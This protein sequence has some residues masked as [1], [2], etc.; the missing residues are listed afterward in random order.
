MYLYSFLVKSGYSGHQF[1]LDSHMHS[2]IGAGQFWKKALYD[3]IDECSAMIVLWSEH[4]N[5]SKWCFAELTHA[6]KEGKPIFP[7]VVHEGTL[8]DELRVHQ[9][10]YPYKDA[11]A[12][13]RLLSSLKEQ[14]LGA[15]DIKSTAAE[16]PT[17]IHHYNRAIGQLVISEAETR[18]HLPITLSLGKSGNLGKAILHWASEKSLPSV[19]DFDAIIAG[20]NTIDAKARLNQAIGEMENSLGELNFRIQDLRRQKNAIEREMNEIKATSPPREPS[21]LRTHSSPDYQHDQSE[22]AVRERAERYMR[23]IR[24]YEASMEKYKDAVRKY[25]ERQRSLPS[26]RNRLDALKQQIVQLQVQSGDLKLTSIQNLA[27][28][29]EAVN[30]A[31]SRDIAA[32]FITVRDTAS[33]A[34]NDQQTKAAGFYALLTAK[35]LIPLFQPLLRDSLILVKDVEEEIEQLLEDATRTSHLVVGTDFLSR[36]QAP[37]N[38]MYENG[39]E[40]STIRKILALL[41]EDSLTDVTTRIQ[42]ATSITFPVIPD[43]SEV[44][45]PA[46]FPIENAA[47]IKK[48]EEVQHGMEKC[49]TVSK[50]TLELY[51][52]TKTAIQKAEDC[53]SRMKAVACHAD[54]ILN[55]AILLSSIMDSVQKEKLHEQTRAFVVSMLEEVRSRFKKDHASLVTR[56]KDSRWG[57]EEA[58][59]ILASHPA[60]KFLQAQIELTSHLDNLE[61]CLEELEAARQKLESRPLQI[62]EEFH[63]RMGS[64]VKTSCIPIIQLISAIQVLADRRLKSI[65]QSQLPLLVPLRQEVVNAVL[66]AAMCASMVALFGTALIVYVWLWMPGALRWDNYYIVVSAGVAACGFFSVVVLLKAWLQFRYWSCESSANTKS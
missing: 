31:R 40:L 21:G 50:E 46:V 48:Q 44:Y 35:V 13:E 61:K 60:K 45:D 8:P 20:I 32:L 14:Y 59:Q 29:E 17:N 57:L 63:N 12:Y 6:E 51:K 27:V 4:W 54:E 37:K 42:R 1:F 56:C 11:K 47:L 53:N 15:E 7:V 58:N 24:E 23:E 16:L 43:F 65:L 19:N 38:A 3:R 22:W 64:L 30:N 66:K 41:P 26:F 18:T 49:R 33:Q 36:W 28:L 62:Y 9:A 52:E 2:G 39:S 25:D 55:Q 5:A 10:V 34:M